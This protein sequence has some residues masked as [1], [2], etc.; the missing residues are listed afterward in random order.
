[1]NVEQTAY[2]QYLQRELR[3]ARKRN[4]A[5]AQAVTILSVAVVTLVCLLALYCNA[6]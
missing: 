2:T 1:M 4:E 6:L 3:I 5:Y